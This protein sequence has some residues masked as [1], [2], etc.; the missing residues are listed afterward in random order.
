MS[1]E[2]KAW[3]VVAAISGAVLAA[4]ILGRWWAWETREQ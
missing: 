1:R 3:F 2:E 4:H